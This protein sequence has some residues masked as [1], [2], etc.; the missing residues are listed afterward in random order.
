MRNNIVST[1]VKLNWTLSVLKVTKKEIR[2]N[3]LLYLL[4]V[5]PLTYFIVFKYVPMYGIILAFRKY[6]PGKSI[7]GVEWVGFKYFK[8]FLTDFTFWNVFKN[9]VVLNFFNLIFGFP[10]PIIFALLLN[11]VRN[12]YY[13]KVV[14]TVSYLP[15]FFSTVVVVS[16]I[17][18][19]VSPSTGVVNK[20]L[21]SFGVEAIHFLNE[22]AWFR[23]IYVISDIW[24]F[25]GWNA[26][27]YLAALSGVDMQ[28]YEAAVIDGASKWKQVI[29]ITIPSIMPTII[30]VFILSVGNILAVGFEKILLLYSPSIYETA[31]VIQ[32]YV[33]RM[34]LLN[35]NFSYATAVGVFQAIISLWL[36]WMMNRFARKYSDYSLW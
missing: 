18:S 33:Y 19:L 9:T 11:E 27:L 36:L 22:P 25:M 2:K 35:N 8:Q 6:V 23:P 16:M 31:D 21:E 28:L 12:K 29:Y 3:Y 14:Q 13:K 10:I 4:L 5:L 15:R 32:T 17:K 20:V 24:Q 34:G 30:I 1:P 7:F 26:I